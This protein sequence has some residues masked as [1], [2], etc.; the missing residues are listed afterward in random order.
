MKPIV[1]RVL[2]TGTAILFAILGIVVGQSAT[3]T[4]RGEVKDPQGAMIPGAAVTITNLSTNLVRSQA[5]TDTGRFSFELVP[6]G[7]Y[8]IEVEAQ[9]FRKSVVSPVHALVNQAIEVNVKMEL[10]SVSEVVQV[11]AIGTAIKINTQDATLGHNF[12]TQQILQLPMEAR[13]VA[14]LLTL[15][16]GV[17]RDGYV[18]GARSDQSN[19]TL[20]G[21][22]INDAQTSS[23][24]GTVLRLNSEAIEEFRVTTVNSNADQGRSSA[25]QVNLVTKS[26]TNKFHGS[27]FEYLRD[28]SFTANDFFNNR[29]VDAF[30]NQTIPRPKLRRNTYGGT[31]GGPIKKDKLFFFYSY[32]GRSD[33]SERTEVRVVPLSIL[34]AG[35]MRYTIADGSTQVLTLA[36]LNQAFPAVGINPVAVAALA[37]AAKKYPANDFTVGDSQPGRPMNTAGF[38]FNASAPVDLNSNVAKIDWY[39]NNHQ[40]A[41]FRVNAIY[42]LTNQSPEFP[43]TPQPRTWSH[44]WGMVGSHTWTVGSHLVNNFRYGFTRQASTAFGDSTANAIRF[45][46]VFSPY[47]YTRTVNR[48]T[49]VHNIVDDVSWVKGNHTFQLGTNIRVTR[50]S[51][52]SYANAYDDAITNP[53]FYSSSGA[54]VSR[55][56]NSYLTAQGLTTMTSVSEGQNAA[57]AL[58][59]RFSQYSA[60]YTY[61]ING[62]LL[63]PG[64]PTD[65]TFATE[66]YDWY[67]Q[68][69]WRIRRN[70][71]VTYG[72]RYGLSRPVYETGG[73]EVKPTIPLGEYFNRRVSGMNAGVPYAD[74][75]VL[76]RSGPANNASPMYNWDKNNFQPRVAL[77]WSPGFERGLLHKIFGGPDKSVIRGGFAMTNDY[78]GQALAVNFDLNTALGFSSNDTISANTYNVTSRPG[79]LFTGFNQQVRPLPQIT[80]P[81]QM[82]LQQPLDFARR[83][84]TGL[85]GALIAPTNYT[86]NLTIERQLPAGFVMQASYI[87]RAGRNLLA[88]RDPVTPN[89]LRDPKSGQDWFTAAT[90][91]EK[92]RQKGFTGAVPK[93]PFFE[94]MFP[95]LR[96]VMDDYYGPDALPEGLS[97]TET[98]YYIM[99]DW[100]YGNDWTYLQ[101]EMDL[102][103]NKS[104]FWQP[105]YGA[106]SAWSTVANSNYNAMTLS[107]RQ[108]FRDTLQ[109]D[110]NYTMSH[111][112]DDASGLQADGD[113]STGAFIISPLNQRA[114]YSNSDF[115]IRHMININGIY[116]LPF[117]R[118]RLIGGTAPG[119]VHAIVGDWQL[120]GIFRWNTG[121]PA[122]GPYDD[123]RWATNWNVQSFVTPT[124]PVST[125]VTKGDASSAPKLFGCNTNEVYQSLRNAYPGEPGPR[126]IFRLPSYIALDM[127]LAKSFRMPWKE[128]HKLQIRW[129]VFNVTNTQRF[130]DQDTSRTGMGVR[131]DPA[132]N[133]LNA[134]ANWSNFTGIQ[135]SP[136]VMQ[137]GARFEF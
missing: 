16:P 81:P 30:T 95:N 70:L 32:E 38:R 113:Y 63:P 124:R 64:T 71:T 78:F 114:S 115:D 2:L 4:I 20:D 111:S 121:L 21:V 25:A 18:A 42:D 67:F 14:A 96:N 69:A 1:F 86:W 49:P 68:D 130:G 101:D 110:F 60:N 52:L 31:I 127:G 12:V 120:S 93:Q 43:D 102:A 135:G 131:L 117:G 83:I 100:E 91:L 126:N 74:P 89:N 123:A 122:I 112:L 6:V 85:D 15:Q 11:D 44:P 22:D 13:N 54:V 46:F 133:K 118:G 29:T 72:L 28:T 82:P 79:P 119:W 40:S 8:K 109:W 48:T 134:P 125:C 50:N 132:L 136:R 129:E 57:T 10:G 94:N 37:D 66:E 55:A 80:V 75:I 137:I 47:S 77:S 97:P 3:S 34:G 59:G 128:G 5:T 61:D 106:L 41:F 9:A 99:H 27:A 23:L 26:G 76:E 87:G 65:R 88:Q 90:E 104:W 39:I 53:S 36:Q 58:I 35:S 56:I 17:T 24:S 45:R 105:Q 108:R 84:E 98:V 116:G 103:Y 62:N 51:R 7:D 92:L 33:K 73:F 19:I 107:L